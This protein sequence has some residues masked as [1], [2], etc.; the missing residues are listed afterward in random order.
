MTRPDLPADPDA[1]AA[2]TRQ[3]AIGADQEINDLFRA[4]PIHRR[5][6]GRH[7]KERLAVRIIQ[8][9]H[10]Y[11]DLAQRTPG[12]VEGSSDQASA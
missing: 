8:A 11:A 6:W 10:H 12:P 3:P 2:G 7:E 9:G 1:E 5:W 4:M